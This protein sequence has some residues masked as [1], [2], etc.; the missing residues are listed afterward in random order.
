MSSETRDLDR[1]RHGHGPS[2]RE[3]NVRQPVPL[4]DRVHRIRDSEWQTLRTVGTFRVV[5][6]ADLLRVAGDQ[7][8][9]RNDV[10]HLV[11]EGLLD[12]KTGMVNH[13]PTRLLTLSPDG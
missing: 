8:A 4:R 6:E 13:H 1:Q 5:A 3:A 11:D 7:K 12:R 9:M 2:T 10:R